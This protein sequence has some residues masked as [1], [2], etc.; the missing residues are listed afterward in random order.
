MSKNEGLSKANE[1]Q[2]NIIG[3][4][5]YSGL[6]ETSIFNQARIINAIK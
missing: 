1:E 4:T 2:P 5:L 3:T 6:G